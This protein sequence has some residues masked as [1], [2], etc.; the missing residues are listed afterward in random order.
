MPGMDIKP[1]LV[2][3]L[4]I[5]LISFSVLQNDFIYLGFKMSNKVL[6]DQTPDCN[7]QSSFHLVLGDGALSEYIKY[8]SRFLRFLNIAA[9]HVLLQWQTI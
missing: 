6:K 1:A 7:M 4:Y 2:S 3:P 8:F 5:T 9:P